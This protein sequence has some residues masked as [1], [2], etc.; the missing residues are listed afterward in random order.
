MIFVPIVNDQSPLSIP[1]DI[2][3]SFLDLNLLYCDLKVYI[4]K[5]FLSS[6]IIS[7][8]LVSHSVG[9]G[10]RPLSFFVNALPG[11]QTYHTK[12]EQKSKSEVSA[13]TCGLH[14]EQTVER[15]LEG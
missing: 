6:G 8:P 10:G 1:I 14:I 5:L 15:G 9:F 12:I 4:V 13:A 7:T 3:V 2:D 11:P